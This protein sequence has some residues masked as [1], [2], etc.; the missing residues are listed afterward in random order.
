MGIAM[1]LPVL[2]GEAESGKQ[3]GSRSQKLELGKGHAASLA[4]KDPSSFVNRLSGGKSRFTR[5]II[6]L[7]ELNLHRYSDHSTI[8]SK[9]M[10]KCA[11]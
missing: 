10:F 1:K 2:V 11:T 7:G 9:Q 5:R 8:V 3:P 4:A 6:I